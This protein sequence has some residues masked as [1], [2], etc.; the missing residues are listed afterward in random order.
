MN[1]EESLGEWHSRFQ[2]F[3]VDADLIIVSLFFFFRFT[4]AEE[5]TVR[6]P[7]VSIW[8]VTVG[9]PEDPLPQKIT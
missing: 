8:S 1:I 2:Q 5:T 3:S 6:I 9:R 7:S 4:G